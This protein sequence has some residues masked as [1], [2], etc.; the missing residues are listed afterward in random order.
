MIHDLIIKIMAQ[1]LRGDN[2]ALVGLQGLNQRFYSIRDVFIRQISLDSDLS[3]KVYKTRPYGWNKVYSMKLSHD[4]IHELGSLSNLRSLSLNGWSCLNI[5]ELSAFKK[6]HTI[7]LKYCYTI[8]GL[9]VLKNVHNV[10][11]NKCYGIIDTELSALKDVHTLTIQDCRNIP[12]HSVIGS[13]HHKLVLCG[14]YIYDLTTFAN[15][16]HLELRMISYGYYGP[17]LSVLTGVHTLKLIDCSFLRVV[18]YFKSVQHLYI[19]NCIHLIDIS[20]TRHI[21][22]VEIIHCPNIKNILGRYFSISDKAIYEALLF[23]LLGGALGHVIYQ[24]ALKH[25]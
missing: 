12:D 9:S 8:I 21:P 20:A 3:P 13:N 2:R 19:D 22:H 6:L 18:P 14:C 11:L 4:D 1:Y 24:L 15:I 23:G 17:D 5:L 10:S 7:K 16:Y 25:Q